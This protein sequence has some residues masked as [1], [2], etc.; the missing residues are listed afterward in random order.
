MKLYVCYGT[1]K[2]RKPGGHPC[3]NA[4]QSLVAAGYQ[5]QIERTYGCVLNPAFKGRR[6]V[7]ELTGNYQVPTLILDD[8]SLIDGTANIIA[9]AQENPVD[10]ASRFARSS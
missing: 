4:C 7:N 2:S 9:W 8:G 3:R 5:P 6:E 10:S 1:F